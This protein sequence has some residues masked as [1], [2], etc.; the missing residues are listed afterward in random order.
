MGKRLQDKVA[1]VTGSTS[2]IGRA[3]AELFAEQGASVVINGRRREL[4]QEVVDGIVAQ[5]DRV[6]VLDRVARYR[7]QSVVLTIS[8]RCSQGQATDTAGPAV[9]QRIDEAME[10]H[11]YA[12]EIL[13]D[14]TGRIGTGSSITAT[15]IRSI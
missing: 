5:G 7:L 13:P 4:G 6:E 9:A 3:S 8:D 11:V 2:G 10:A 15:G 12:T 14:E 1:V